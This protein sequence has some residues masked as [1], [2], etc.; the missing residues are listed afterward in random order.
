MKQPIRYTLPVL[1]G[2]YGLCG[3]LRN[4][5]PEGDAHETEDRGYNMQHLRI[6]QERHF[7][8]DVLA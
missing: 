3:H 7:Q 4:H 6:L 2:T 5:V 8:R 1:R